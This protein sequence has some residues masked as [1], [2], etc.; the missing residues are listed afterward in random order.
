MNKLRYDIDDNVPFVKLLMLSFQ[1]LFAMFGATILVP[2]TVNKL[3]GED[4][5]STGMALLCSGIGTIV[6]ILC[7]KSKS[8]AYLSSSFAYITPMVVGFS[9]AGKS[10]LLTSVMAVGLVYIIFSI[11]IN[12]VG[13]KWID[14]VF[15]PI[16]IGPMI[17]IIGLSLAP[18]A[19][20]QI[21]LTTTGAFELKS[22][23]VAIV[24]FFTTIITSVY[25]KGFIKVVPFLCGILTGYV[26][27]I[28][29]GMVDFNPILTAPLFCIPQFSIPLISY[30]LNFNAIL[31]MIPVALVSI[32]EHIGSHSVL[33][34]LINHNLLKD[35]GLDK[36]LLGNGLGTL[37]SGFL[38]GTPLT[39]YSENISVVGLTKVASTNVTSLTAIIVIF[40]AFSGKIMAL[41]NS[42]PACCLG[43][44]S[45]ILYGFIALNGLKILT[46]A[47]LDL[48]N[49]RNVAIISTMLILG[50]GGSIVDLKIVSLSGLSLAALVGIILNLILPINE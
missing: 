49:F 24:A 20:E 31:T 46:K 37:M 8:P 12:R 19:I 22:V 21:G 38:G 50:L 39:P 33:G 6:Y 29:F 43:G 18:T 13:K 16:V 1:H 4:V 48:T 28:L 26:M 23:I 35:P 25:C 10:G 45:L 5:L 14:R 34:E 30:E 3:V 40:M 41:I 9:M 17:L 7:T 27:A 2:M 47:K 42:I 44:V 32:S 15:P 36:T 11:V